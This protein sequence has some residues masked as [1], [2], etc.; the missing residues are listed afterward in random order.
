MRAWTWIA[1]ALVLF[2]A[3]SQG[4]DGAADPRTALADYLHKP[5]SSYRWE[6]KRVGKLRGSEFVE[7]LLVSQTW[8]DIPW[9]HQLFVIKPKK[10]KNHNGHGLLVIA[11]GRW[12]SEYEGPRDDA[13]L[14]KRAAVFARLAKMLG[15]PVAVLRQVPH[16]PLFDGLTEDRMIAYSFDQYLRTADPEWP[17]LLPMTKSARR[18]MDAVQEFAQQEWSLPLETFTV[19]G[20]SKRGWTTWL[21]GATDPRVTALVPVVIDMLSL[22]S[23]LAH[24]RNVWGNLSYKISPYTDI[25]L[26]ARLATDRGRA[27]QHI[28]DPYRYRAQLTQPKL[29]VVGTND[30]YWPLDA[31]NLYWADLVGPK[32]ALYVPNERHSISDYRRVLGTVGALHRHAAAGAKLPELDWQFAEQGDEIVLSVSVDPIPRRVAAWVAHSPTRDFRQANW[33][34]QRLKRARDSYRFATRKPAEGYTALFGEAVFGKRRQRYYLSSNVRI[35]D[36][37]GVATAV[38]ANETASLN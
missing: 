10:L 13:D 25:D 33:G 36:H 16:Q 17:L 26:P 31:L 22:E 20:G 14:P 11:G 27:L 9:K 37:N 1:V 32:Y 4:A 5:D 23:Q 35:I 2:G 6:R 8:R 21:V 12:R 19:L 29:I 38:R 7:L 30:N 18:A 15:T 34:S 28:V 24:Q 3:A